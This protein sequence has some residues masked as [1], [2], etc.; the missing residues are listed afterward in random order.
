MK[1]TSI[2]LVFGI[3]AI[4]ASHSFAGQ[5]W[6]KDCIIEP[7]KPTT[8]D[9]IRIT[10]WGIWSNAS[11]PRN[12]T[13]SVNN[14]SIYFDII[15]GHAKTDVS[16]QPR[17]V[18]A[19]LQIITPWKL[20]ES[21]G[22]LGQ[23]RYSVYVRI[24]PDPMS[25]EPY[26]LMKEFVVTD[27]QFVL[28]AESLVVKEK[29]T[30]G[31]K[32]S[33]LNKP[34]HDVR[35]TV[36]YQSGDGDLVIKSGT[37]L[38]FNPSNYSKPQ[39]VLLGANDD[40]D[41][42]NGRASIV[43]S[44]DG[45]LTAKCTLIEDDDDAPTVL[46]V[47]GRADSGYRNHSWQETIADLE[48][49][50][51]AVIRKFPVRD[52][53]AIYAEKH[54]I[55]LPIYKPNPSKLL[56]GML[57]DGRRGKSWR[58]AF[59]DLQEALT[60]AAYVPSVKE[61]HV[62]QGVYKPKDRLSNRHTTF[63]ISSGIAIKGG[64]AGL[65]ATQPDARDLQKYE[66]ILTGDL[67]GNDDPDFE[68]RTDNSYT[69]VKITQAKAGTVL[70]GITVTG[71]EDMALQIWGGEPT[72]SNCI[73]RYNRGAYGAAVRSFLAKPTLTNCI[74]IGNEINNNKIGRGA[75]MYAD[76]KSEVTLNNCLFLSNSAT[77]TAG[78][79]LA[80]SPANLTNC[81]FWGNRDK[82]GTKESAQLQGENL[83]LKNCHIQGWTGKLGGIGNTD[84]DSSI[85][86]Q[87]K[88]YLGLLNLINANK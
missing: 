12:S 35:V 16:S 75:G 39:T 54:G 15:Y 18:F 61:I 17:P 76:P 87:S 2:F 21:I 36:A 41:Y 5:N 80:H 45:F 43:I 68:N 60:I 40:K 71:A 1:K 19:A 63:E 29:Q 32:V 66:T 30:A 33:L 82:A 51:M 73:F 28:S 84:I 24:G 27:K 67:K 13:I 81:V 88:P 65:G 38:T 9:V 31:L 85:I 70:D 4:M 22:P 57:L 10:M 58:F 86:D 44:A 23:G 64:Y 77:D 14:R 52:F 79:L 48:K 55:S 69:L 26:M 20:E 78:G 49:A 47:D 59:V 62:A 72:I 8:S 46:Y 53:M 74:F 3:L 34:P 7:E 42:L 37:S 25:Q 56:R 83:I 50:R 6:P 11:I